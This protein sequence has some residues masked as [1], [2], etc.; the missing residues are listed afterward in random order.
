MTGVNKVILLGNV[1]R[2]PEVRYTQNGTAVANF[3]IAT[4]EVFGGRDGVVGKVE[5]YNVAKAE[6]PKQ[7]PAK[8]SGL[9]VHANDVM[10]FYAPC[11]GGYG[12]ALERDPA[13]VLDDVLDDYYSADEARDIYGVVVDL[14]TETVD[15]A[16][17]KALRAQMS[18]VAAE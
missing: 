7:V 12:N 3:S 17:T 9:R 8:F 2:D 10:A 16:A 13:L 14:E 18:A 4:S 1:G 15:I 11:G 5:I 6:T